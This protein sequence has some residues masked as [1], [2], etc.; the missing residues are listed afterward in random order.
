MQPLA[1]AEKAGAAWASIAGAANL[2]DLRKIPGRHAAEV[3]AR[4]SAASRGRSPTAVSFP[5]INTSCTRQDATT[6]CRCSRATT[7]T[8]RRLVRQRH[9]TR[10]VRHDRSAALREICR[11]AARRISVGRGRREKDRARPDTRYDV[12]LAHV[13]VGATPGEDG[14]GDQRTSITSTSTPSNPADSPRFGFGSPHAA[15]MAYVFSHFLNRQ[16]TPEDLDAVGHD[17][18]R[19]GPTSRRQY[20]PIVRGIAVAACVPRRRA[21]DDGTWP[22]RRKPSR[23]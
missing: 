5:T 23:S 19:I 22:A 6:T 18:Q 14:Q 12:R 20:D 15:E 11:P 7:P 17:D 13:D 4:P 3:C 2:A 1:A 10:R 21:S 16:P 9:L 8:R